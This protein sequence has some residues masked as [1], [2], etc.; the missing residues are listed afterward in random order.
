M[1]I[2]GS[3]L[4]RMSR[5]SDLRCPN[6]RFLPVCELIGTR[7]SGEFCR[8]ELHNNF[9]PLINVP[10]EP[11]TAFF[12]SLVPGSRVAACYGQSYKRPVYQRAEPPLSAFGSP[13]HH[14]LFLMNCCHFR[15]F[16]VSASPA[17]P[18]FSDQTADINGRTPD[19]CGLC[20]VPAHSQKSFEERH[21]ERSKSST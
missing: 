15:T 10:G 2:A 16:V 3:P 13:D 9:F 7:V 4:S 1:R 14:F 5:R 20:V 8:G 6:A 21:D 19:E 17:A 18:S 12:A 11:G